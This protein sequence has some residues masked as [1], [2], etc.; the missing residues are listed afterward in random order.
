M[1]RFEI[2]AK[3]G[4]S[5]QC[6]TGYSSSIPCPCRDLFRT[7]TR[8][9]AWKRTGERGSPSWRPCHRDLLPR[10][11]RAHQ[12][13][14]RGTSEVEELLR[15][16]SRLTAVAHAL[17][18][19]FVRAGDR[20][21][22]ATAGNGADALFLARAV[23]PSGHLTI[24]DIQEDA[25]RSTRSVLEDSDEGQRGL[26]PSLSFVVGCHSRLEEHVQEATLVCFNLGYLPG[27]G[28]KGLVTRADT[29]LAALQAVSRVLR[30]GGIISVLAYHTHP[31]GEEEYEA[32]KDFMAGLPTSHW[33]TFE[34]RLVNRPAAPILL[35]AWRDS[36]QTASD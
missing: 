22:D 9:A 12:S 10:T 30:P 16:G 4:L 19:Q 5:I 21:V 25:V 28:R 17:W 27:W 36:R 6:V 20:V 7:R 26:L 1:F 3:S 2:L 34:Q 24:I 32:V 11:R 33:T 29:T 8:F 14:G 23:G 35:V 31:G 18:G 13:A 15:G